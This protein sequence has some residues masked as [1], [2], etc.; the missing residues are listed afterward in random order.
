M[1]RLQ[2]KMIN[3]NPIQSKKIFSVLFATAFFLKNPK[4]RIN[5]KTTGP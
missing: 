3:G 5:K 2:M 1:E 4:M